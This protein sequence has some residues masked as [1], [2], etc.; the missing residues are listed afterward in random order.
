[1][2]IIEVI[3]LI[4]LNTEIHGWVGKSYT[5]RLGLEKIVTKIN[6]ISFNLNSSFGL[7]KEFSDLIKGKQ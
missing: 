7:K 2:P 5:H 6:A 1:V 4:N 3:P